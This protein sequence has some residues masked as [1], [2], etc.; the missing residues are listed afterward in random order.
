MRRQTQRCLHALDT[1]SIDT[2]IAVRASDTDIAVILL[3]HCDTV[4]MDIGT[5]SK[6]DRRFINI[7][8]VMG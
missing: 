5:T 1:D 3:Y 7:T 4:W 2:N 8:S 6:K